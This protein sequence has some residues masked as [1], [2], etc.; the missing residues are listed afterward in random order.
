METIFERV[1]G[2]DVHTGRARILSETAISPR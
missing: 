2:L 1:G